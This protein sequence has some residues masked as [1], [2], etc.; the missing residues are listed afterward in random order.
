MSADKLNCAN[1]ECKW[2]KA[3]KCILF[4]GV[5]ALQCQYRVEPKTKKTNKTNKRK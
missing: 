4:V 3:G 2:R 5:T 1:T